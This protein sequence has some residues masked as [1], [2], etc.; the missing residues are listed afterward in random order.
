MDTYPFAPSG[1]WIYTFLSYE[2]SNPHLP[3]VHATIHIRLRA[4]R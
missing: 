4:K 2:N 1:T 3:Y